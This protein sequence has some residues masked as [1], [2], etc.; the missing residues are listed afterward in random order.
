MHV[1]I[2]DEVVQFPYTGP[3]ATPRADSFG[4]DNDNKTRFS[5]ETCREITQKS[6]DRKALT[7]IW[8]GHH[9]GEAEPIREFLDWA[10]RLVGTD[11]PT[12]IHRTNLETVMRVEMAPFWLEDEMRVSVF[13]LLLRTSKYF[14]QLKDG[15]RSVR[16]AIESYTHARDTRDAIELFLL[17]ANKYTGPP[18]K[19][20]WPGASHVEDGWVKLAA[21]LS[22]EKYLQRFRRPDPK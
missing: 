21:R 17:G 20:A 2:S 16:K 22:T 3:Y 15:E 12:R 11:P 13:T 8:F 14:A 10:E 19:A 4:V 18:F 1:S 9:P 6:F 7:G 5:W